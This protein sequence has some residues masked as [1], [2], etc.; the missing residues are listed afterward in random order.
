MREAAIRRLGQAMS[1]EYRFRWTRSLRE[2]Q[3]R[4]S[5]AVDAIKTDLVIDCEQPREA[6][7]QALVTAGVLG[8]G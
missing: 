7:R 3:A 4:I 6:K 1:D 8:R 5:A 2:T